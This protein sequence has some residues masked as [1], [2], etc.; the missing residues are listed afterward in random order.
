MS[1]YFENEYAEYLLLGGIVYITYKNGTSI[2]LG[3]SIQIVKDRLQFQEGRPYPVLCDIRGVRE[4]N[5]SARD[6]L[7]NE[8]SLWITAV[9]FIVEPPVTEALSQFYVRA[10]YSPIPTESFGKITEARAFL[11]SFLT[12]VFFHHL[13]FNLML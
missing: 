9:A 12:F 3:A 8:G 2:D 13:L 6:Y 1:D 10:N 5:K 4:V 11:N 7:S